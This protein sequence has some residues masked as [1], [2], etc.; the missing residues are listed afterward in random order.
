MIRVKSGRRILREVKVKR[1]ETDLEAHDRVVLWM[2][3]QP[4]F[5]AL[6]STSGDEHTVTVT[7]EDLRDE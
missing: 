3:Q 6:V 2:A 1:G 5:V 7:V 4:E